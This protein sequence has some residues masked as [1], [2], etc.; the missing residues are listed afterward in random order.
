MQVDSRNK[1]SACVGAETRP[2][3][4]DVAIVAQLQFSENLIR[5]AHNTSSGSFEASSTRWLALGIG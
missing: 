3:K 4:L 5:I 1:N 2:S